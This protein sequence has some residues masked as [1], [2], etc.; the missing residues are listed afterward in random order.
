[1][2]LGLY[3]ISLLILLVMVGAPFTIPFNVKWHMQTKKTN[4]NRKLQLRKV[5]H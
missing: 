3:I 1:M 5:R 4:N 2:K